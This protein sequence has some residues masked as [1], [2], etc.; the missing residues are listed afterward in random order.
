MHYR[1]VAM[2]SRVLG[3]TVNPKIMQWEGLGLV[4]IPDE[5]MQEVLRQNANMVGRVTIL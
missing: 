2:D 4:Y 5:Q 1:Q 3:R